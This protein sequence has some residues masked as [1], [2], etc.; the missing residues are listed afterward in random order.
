[1]KLCFFKG[2]TSSLCL[3]W[4]AAV[5]AQTTEVQSV[6]MAEFPSGARIPVAQELADTLANKA[7]TAIFA[8]GGKARYEF[9]GQNL[10]VDLLPGGR[11]NGPWRTEDGRLC[12]EF[13]SRFP[14]GCSDVR[15]HE[16]KLVVRR[17]STGELITL[18]PD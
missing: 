11:D 16:G 12:A 17:T 6:K 4:A 1:M 8:N 3:L 10:Y 7:W 2:P 13:R 9:R 15:V 14:S 18:Q 5:C